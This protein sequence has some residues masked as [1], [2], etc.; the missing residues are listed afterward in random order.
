VASGS[1]PRAIPPRHTQPDHAQDRTSFARSPCFSGARASCPPCWPRNR[2]Q[3]NR[4]QR[5]SSTR[6]R[7]PGRF[8][9]ESK[10]SGLEPIGF[11]ARDSVFF[12]V[13]SR[14]EPFAGP[15]RF[16]RHGYRH[17]LHVPRSILHE[18]RGRARER[19][20]THG[21]QEIP[22]RVR[23]RMRMIG[24]V[25][26]SWNE[27]DDRNAE[28]DSDCDPDADPTPH[29]PQPRNIPRP[30]GRFFF[31]GFAAVLRFFAFSEKACLSL[32]RSYEKAY[33]SARR[34]VAPTAQKKRRIIVRSTTRDWRYPGPRPGPG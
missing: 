31:R 7:V 4:K 1:V 20:T 14:P 33:S 26:G 34:R 8:L 25:A 27:T 11:S 28:I 32:F 29:P 6:C 19:F 12:E 23:V 16:S 15:M 17:T 30:P 9:N 2:H 13:E 21:P 24:A 18:P 3:R 5:V 22:G 10:R